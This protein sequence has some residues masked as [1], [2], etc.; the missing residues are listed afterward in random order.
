M[1]FGRLTL[2]LEA[3]ERRGEEGSSGL[4]FINKSLFL[5]RIMCPQT[6]SNSVPPPPTK[7]NKARQKQLLPST[8]TGNY[9]SLLVIWALTFLVYE[10]QLT[11]K[12]L[13]PHPQ[14]THTWPAE[15]DFQH[16]KHEKVSQ[17]KNKFK[18][19]RNDSTFNTVTKSNA[20]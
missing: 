15:Q 9:F 14:H 5:E 8:T 3:C 10:L 2:S 13:N 18:S 11:L 1:T 4:E 12:F 20:L 17:N 16:G 19:M 6:L 7:I